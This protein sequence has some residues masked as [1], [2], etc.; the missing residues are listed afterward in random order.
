MPSPS[1]TAVT[2]LSGFLG[3]GK[4][5]LLNHLL[6][7]AEGQRWAL[8]VN[9]VGAINLDAR[10]IAQKSAA[11]ERPQGSTAP[12]L[13]ELANGCV[14]CA[15]KDD[16][17]E[18]LCRLAA[19]GRYEHILVETTGVA[20]PRGIA[21]LFLQKNFF[22]RSVSDFA[23]LQVLVTVVDAADFL[24]QS[25]KCAS[26]QNATN[27]GTKR[28]IELL[29]EQIECADLI[30]LNKCDLIDESQLLELEG[31][32]SGLNP[33]AELFRTEQ[34]QAPRELVMDRQRFEAAETMRA[35][36]WV[37][38]LNAIAPNAQ[39]EPFSA[40]RQA[41]VHVEDQ[42]TLPSMAAQSAQRR[43][44]TALRIEPDYTAKYGLRSFAFQARRPFSQTRL[45]ALLAQGLSGIV[46]AKGFYWLKVRPDEMGFLSIAGGVVK[47]E[48]LNYWWAAMIENGKAR[49][50]ERPLMIRALWQE[51]HGDRRQEL[52]FIGIGYDEAALRR[53][54]EACLE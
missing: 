5:T 3:A 27:S 26:E 42:S 2:V 29:I 18:T 34:G 15:I 41:G 47:K 54:L 25:H 46:R 53:A 45:D 30:I 4:T 33:R 52:V 14:C 24:R 21:Q 36:R 20:E 8:I 13:V 49:L 31:L 22:G 11:L 38:E 48:W 51:P 16:L 35:A 40:D 44:P 32:I 28:L 43:V 1:L 39:T 17:A 23:R 9:D 6:P 12:E 37:G 7:Q 50:D 10:L 19:Q